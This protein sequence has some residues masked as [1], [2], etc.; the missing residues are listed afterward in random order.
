M[1]KKQEKF[2]CGRKLLGMLLAIALCMQ[3]IVIPV[4]A[5]TYREDIEAIPGWKI[6]MKY[7]DAESYATTEFAYSGKASMKI[8]NRTAYQNDVYIANSYNLSVEKGHT[9]H[10][11]FAIKAKNAANA[12]VFIDWGASGKKS[13]LPFGGTCDWQE[14]GFTYTHTADAKT[15]D[16][17][18]ML[19]NKGILWIDDIYFYDTQDEKKE[20]MI[21]NP[22]FEGISTTKNPADDASGTMNAVP[23]EY[24]EDILVDGNISDWDAIKKIEITSLREYVKEGNKSLEATIAYAYDKENFYFLIEVEDDVHVS[25]MDTTHWKADSVQFAL[26]NPDENYGAGYGIVYDPE[27]DT[28]QVYTSEDVSAKV[29]RNGTKTVYEASIPWTLRNDGIVPEMF[30]FNA[31]INDNDDDGAGRKYCLEL[32]PGIADGK[33]GTFYPRLLPINTEGYNVWFDGPETVTVKNKATY[34]LTLINGSG[35]KRTFKFFSNLDGRPVSVELSPGEVQNYPVETVYDNIGPH[36]ITLTIS[37]GEKDVVKS[38]VTDVYAD[39]TFSQRVIADQEK[40]L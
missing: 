1:Q 31:I 33:Y 32:A 4:Y 39:L 35:V 9:Y 13:V 25:I 28:T 21:E 17:R 2:F 40:N 30:K 11:G 20:N 10:Y 34:P 15:I 3:M 19:E 18:I 16:L 5:A 23:V 14:M 24:K 29:S 27:T 8:E 6:I 37:D 26:C 38:V 36:T 7:A 22:S 12:N